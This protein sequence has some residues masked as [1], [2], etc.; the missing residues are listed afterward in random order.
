MKYKLGMKVPR[1]I[2]AQKAI[3]SRII[4]IGMRILAPVAGRGSGKGEVTVRLGQF[5]TGFGR[6]ELRIRPICLYVQRIEKNTF[7]G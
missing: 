6:F 4:L 2:P 1:P 3:C 7:S 5:Q